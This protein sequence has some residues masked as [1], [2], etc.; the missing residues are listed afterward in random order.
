MA[1]IK[2]S[3]AAVQAF[4]DGA[5]EAK[6]AAPPKSRKGVRRGNREQITLTLPPEVI[7]RIDR[8][9][10]HLG[11]SRAAY[12]VQAAVRALEDGL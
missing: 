4:V 6:T 12:L 7:D 11:I 2:A 3:R 1:I 10:N 8:R 5:A 9:A